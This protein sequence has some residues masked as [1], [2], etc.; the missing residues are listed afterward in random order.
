V[1]LRGVAAACHPGDVGA[2]TVDDRVEQFTQAIAPRT[3]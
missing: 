3:W 2:L 1:E